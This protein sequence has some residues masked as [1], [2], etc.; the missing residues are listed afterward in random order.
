MFYDWLKV[1]R[2]CN[3]KPCYKTVFM[4]EKIKK[5]S[6]KIKTAFR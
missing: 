4:Y 1:L 3:E 5:P 6:R 2:R